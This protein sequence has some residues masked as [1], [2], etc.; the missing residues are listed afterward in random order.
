MLY[1]QTERLAALLNTVDDLDCFTHAELPDAIVRAHKLISVASELAKSAESSIGQFYEVYTSLKS[2]LSNPEK[3]DKLPG[4]L[5]LELLQAVTGEG[6]SASLIAMK[7]SELARYA[8]VDPSLKPALEY[9]MELIR[10]QGFTTKLKRYQGIDCVVEIY[11]Q[12]EQSKP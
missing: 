10:K 3:G 5:L 11:K 4:E 6:D 12:P 1:Q 2:R 8:E 7:A 9:L